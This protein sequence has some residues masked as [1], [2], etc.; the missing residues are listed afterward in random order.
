MS[1]AIEFDWDEHNRS[2]LKTHRVSAGEFEELILNEP[3]DLDYQS[4]NGEDRFKSLGITR[5]GRILVVAWTIRGS[6]IRAVTAYA[7]GR[8]YQELYWQ[9]KK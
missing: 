2:H 6:K 1:D 8:R 5:R 4:V 3:L 9:V 7:A